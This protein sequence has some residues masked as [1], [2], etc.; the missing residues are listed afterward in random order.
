MGGGWRE[1][2]IFHVIFFLTF[3]VTGLL[4]NLVQLLV[5]L[6]LVTVLGNRR[7]FRRFNYY[8]IYIIYGQLLF[9]VDWW[10]KA[11]I[12]IYNKVRIIIKTRTT[13]S[14]S[15]CLLLVLTLYCPGW[16]NLNL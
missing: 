16:V 9:L 6:L 4:V 3:L 11:D 12:T 14:L 5:Y 15:R 2:S 8:C 7:L 1:W 10:S 13:T